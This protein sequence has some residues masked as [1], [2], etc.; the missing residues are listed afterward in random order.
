M[1]TETGDKFDEEGHRQTSEPPAKLDVAAVHS[2]DHLRTTAFFKL[3]PGAIVP[4]HERTALEQTYVIEGS[5]ENH[6]DKCRPVVWRP[7]AHIDGW[8]CR[9][10]DRCDP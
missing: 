7:A 6:E 9:C 10:W 4:L 5:L 8:S 2:G 1:A 3:E